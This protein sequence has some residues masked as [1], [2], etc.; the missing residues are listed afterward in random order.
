[1][2]FVSDIEFIRSMIVR[3]LSLAVIGLDNV[4]KMY[5]LSMTI[6]EF[7]RSWIYDS[8]NKFPGTFLVKK[9]YFL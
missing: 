7:F 6:F 9:M 8:I 5:N 4:L 1:M 3:F 2:H